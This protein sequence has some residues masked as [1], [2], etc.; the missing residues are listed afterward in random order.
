M[1]EITDDWECDFEDEAIA[2]PTMPC[3]KGAG[4]CEGKWK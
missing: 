2:I 4:P 1:Q 3:G